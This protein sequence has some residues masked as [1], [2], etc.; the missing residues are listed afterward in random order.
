MMLWVRREKESTT[1]AV[2]SVYDSEFSSTH[3]FGAINVIRCV[4]KEKARRAN[5]TSGN[6]TYSEYRRLNPRNVLYKPSCLLLY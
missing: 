4:V 3:L 1:V 6:P 2:L 5:C